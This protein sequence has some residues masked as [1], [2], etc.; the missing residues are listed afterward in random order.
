MIRRAEA[1]DAKIVHVFN[2]NLQKEMASLFKKTPDLKQFAK[3]QLINPKTYSVSDVKEWISGMHGKS[4]ESL[5]NMWYVA[6][7]EG[8]VIGFIYGEIIQSKT[9]IVNRTG[10]LDA[11]YI[12]KS[13]RK[14]GY[15]TKL[16]NEIMQWFKLKKIKYI[17]ISVDFPNKKVQNLYEKLGFVKTTYIY[18]KKI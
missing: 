7:F 6:E 12:A 2:I 14:N 5:D 3:T 18:N 16:I 9:S 10:H 13:Y 17:D 11:L 8:T 4:D 15:A 1:K